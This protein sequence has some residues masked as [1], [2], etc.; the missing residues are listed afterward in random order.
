MQNTEIEIETLRFIEI[1][2]EIHVD[3]REY[4]GM[5]YAECDVSHTSELCIYESM[6][7]RKTYDRHIFSILD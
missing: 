5:N 3:A 4:M 2:F 7:T 1:G 6:K